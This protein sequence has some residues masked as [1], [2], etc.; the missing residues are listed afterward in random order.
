MDGCAPASAHLKNPGIKRTVNAAVAIILALDLIVA[1]QLLA[2]ILV[3]PHRRINETQIRLIER[4]LP[5]TCR[6]AVE[7][8]PAVR[9]GMLMTVFT[10]V[11]DAFKSTSLP[12]TVVIAATPAVETAI[13][14]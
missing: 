3:Q 11:I 1:S 4:R 14:A 9:Y 8:I 5:A 10:I 2:A 7:D 13:P 6:D 12:L